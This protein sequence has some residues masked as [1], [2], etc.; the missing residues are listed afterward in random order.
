MMVW[1]LIAYLFVVSMVTLFLF[2]GNRP[3]N[4]PQG[5]ATFLTLAAQWFPGLCVAGYDHRRAK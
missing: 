1:F 3:D 5:I 4:L 2:R